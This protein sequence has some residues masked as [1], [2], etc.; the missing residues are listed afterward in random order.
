MRLLLRLLVAAGLAVDAIVHIKL[1]PTLPGASGGG[2]G[3]NALFYAQGA[4]AAIV[5]VLVLAW[6]RR[7]SYAIGFLVAASALGAVLLYYFVDVGKI[8]PLPEMYEPVWYAEK[9]ISAAGEGIA[10]LAA[11]VG[12]IL[13]RAR[14]PES[15]QPEPVRYGVG[16]PARVGR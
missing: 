6:P 10:A 4:V 8:G 1:A 9:T 7:W 15:V 5:G 2:I 12:F 13:G 14:R 3:A 11:F 16:D